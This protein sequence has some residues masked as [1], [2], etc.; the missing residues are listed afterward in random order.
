[1]APSFW[2]KFVKWPKNPFKIWHV[3]LLAF[4]ASNKAQELFPVCS[5]HNGRGDAFRHC[6]WTCLIAKKYDPR[7]ATNYSDFHEFNPHNPCEEAIMDY[8][9]NKTGISYGASG[10]E[11]LKSCLNSNELE[12]IREEKCL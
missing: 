10:Q 1:M 4:E 5:L 2:A 6:Y 7:T 11:C 12:I 3:R 8:K 9:N